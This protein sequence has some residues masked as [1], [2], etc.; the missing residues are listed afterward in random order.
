MAEN[1]KIPRELSALI[2]KIQDINRI[3]DHKLD[4]GL[5]RIVAIGDQSSGK[6]STIEVGVEI[7]NSTKRYFKL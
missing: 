4:L 6:T 2:K 7:R 3:T 5:P 1:Y